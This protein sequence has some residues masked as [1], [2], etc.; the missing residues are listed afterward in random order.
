[1]I[2]FEHTDFWAWSVLILGYFVAIIGTLVPGLPGAF[3][4]VLAAAV[5]EYLRPDTYSWITHASLILLAILS[6]IL[7]F[8]AGIFGAKLGGATK[9]GLYGAMIGGVV[10]IPFGFLGL[11]LGPFVGAIAGDLY[12]HRRDLLELMK[13]GGG[14]ALGFILSLVGRFMILLVMG[15]ILIFGA[16]F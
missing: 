13:S 4:I 15:L 1:M 3:M 6:W 12:G 2:N 14:A 9:Y 16:L 8:V 5:H 7:D 10:G 11:I